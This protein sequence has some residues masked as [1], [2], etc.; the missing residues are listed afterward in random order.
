MS[1]I[2]IHTSITDISRN[3]LRN[4]DFFFIQCTLSLMSFYLRVLFLRLRDATCMQC[5]ACDDDENLIKSSQTDAKQQWHKMS[6]REVF[7]L[8]DFFLSECFSLYDTTPW[9]R[10]AASKA[11]RV[12]CFS[13]RLARLTTHYT[14]TGKVAA[15]RDRYNRLTD[16]SSEST[17]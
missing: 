7:R 11:T 3:Y 10:V 1:K 13:W 15:L 4:T 9:R 14:R 2:H 5:D 17:C 6:R 12:R 8:C 16:H